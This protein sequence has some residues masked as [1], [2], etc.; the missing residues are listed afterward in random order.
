VFYVD[1]SSLLIIPEGTAKR[2]GAKP[3]SIS[4]QFKDDTPMWPVIDHVLT[5]T[6][7]KFYI[8]SRI[9]L[10]IGGPE[11]RTTAPGLY[12][13]G[14]GYK[15]SIGGLTRLIIPLIIA[16]TMILNTMLGSVYERKYE[17]AV[18]NAVG[19][20]PTHIG[21]FFLAEA[22]VYSVIGSVGGYL[23]GQILAIGLT[24][25]D[26]VRGINLNF[27]SLSVVYVIAFT[28]G[29]VLLSTLYPAIVA[30]R[31]AVPSGKRKWSL[32]PHDG[33]RMRL[34]FPF[35]YQPKLAGGIMVYLEE[36]F[37]RF[38]EASFGEL[39]ATLKHKSKSKDQQG[40]DSYRLIY[41]IALAPFDLGVTQ[42]VDFHAVY[43]ELVQ[44]YRIRTTITRLSGQDSNWA[45]TNKP[46]LEKLRKYM[47]NWRNLAPAEHALYIER[48]K[49]T[50][51]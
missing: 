9:P 1:T 35:I 5:V 24:E 3:F 11:G 6:N 49:E 34:V 37:S 20:N 23:I 12:Y 14:S 48:A 41:E 51:G 30:T 16:G 18:Y 46:F 44:S 17:I 7:A 8:G 10:R 13:I 36:Y 43:D 29:I 26:L 31:A 32:P 39:I 50:F 25:F 2:L 47:M 33:D 38:T 42:E 28:I 21:M 19:L 22:F 15:T 45:T 27:S 40:K 4:V